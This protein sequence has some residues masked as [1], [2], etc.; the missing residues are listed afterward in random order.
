MRDVVDGEGPAEALA[1]DDD[2]V[3]IDV[4]PLEKE[5]HRRIDV[6]LHAGERRP[7]LRAAIAT[8][9]EREHVEPGGRHPGDVGEVGADVLR[10]AV[11]VE[12][13][14]VRFAARRHEPGEE[15]RTVGRAKFH[16]L[17][18]DAVDTGA[19]VDRAG[20]LEEHRRTRAEREHEGDEG[21]A[22]LRS[23]AARRACRCRTRGRLRGDARGRSAARCRV[24]A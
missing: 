7:A 9:I 3:R 1:E 5:P 16:R 21:E 18:V 13:R 2:A 12:D 8:V 17:V 14:A 24:R 4:G 19:G 15:R 10:I 6:E 22:H 23:T 20:G 11:Q